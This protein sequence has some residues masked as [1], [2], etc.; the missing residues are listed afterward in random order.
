MKKYRIIIEV[1]GDSPIVDANSAMEAEENFAAE[2]TGDQ[3]LQ[4]LTIGAEEL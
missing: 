1:S 3:L 2:V 4:L